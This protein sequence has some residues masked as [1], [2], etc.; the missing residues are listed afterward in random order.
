MLTILAAGTDMDTP[1]IIVEIRD[2]EP[3]T[4]QVVAYDRFW[5]LVIERLLRGS[6]EKNENADDHVVRKLAA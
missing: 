1:N 2:E 5:K 3:T 4:E 6:E